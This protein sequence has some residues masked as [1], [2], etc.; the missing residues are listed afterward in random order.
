MT[1]KFFTQCGVTVFL[2]S[3]KAFTLLSCLT[4]S[5][6]CF[7]CSCVFPVLFLSV[8]IL[9]SASC[10]HDYI[11]GSP[12]SSLPPD[13]LPPSSVVETIQSNAQLLLDSGP[14]LSLRCQETISETCIPVPV[15]NWQ[16]GSLKAS[17]TTMEC[18]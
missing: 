15:L 16:E 3:I 10:P 9:F 7:T 11:R 5:C 1:S 8:F 4:F 13:P 2:G 6:S 12:P 18:V 17:P 14:P